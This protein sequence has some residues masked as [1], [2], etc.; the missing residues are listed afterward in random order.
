MS[1]PLSTGNVE[2]SSASSHSEDNDLTDLF[3]F[4]EPE[5]YFQPE[6]PPTFV[7]HTLLSGEQLRLRLVGHNPLWGHLLWNAGQ[8]VSK[9]LQQHGEELIRGKDI[10][11]LGAGAGL[12]GLVSAVLGA[13]KVVITDYPDEDLIQ[14]LK[15]NIE[16]CKLL[17][18]RECEI[19]AEGYLWGAPLSANMSTGFDVLILAD[20]LFNHSEHAKLMSTVQQSMR[21]SATS[22]ALVFFTPYRPWLLEK[23]MAFFDLAREAGFNVRNIL[24]TVIE[25]IMFPK[26]RG[27][28]MLRRTVFGYALSWQ[29]V[30]M[31][32]MGPSNIGSPRLFE[33]LA[34][35]SPRNYTDDD[36][37]RQSQQDWASKINCWLNSQV[38]TSTEANKQIDLRARQLLFFLALCTESRDWQRTVTNIVTRAVWHR[39][40]N[41]VAVRRPGKRLVKLPR[42]EPNRRR[43]TRTS[44]IRAWDWFTFSGSSQSSG[45]GPVQFPED[46]IN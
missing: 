26:D 9:Y 5:G 11:E 36:I 44:P 20:L 16:H 10:L 4:Q 19:S 40:G 24:E 41:N 42:K 8:V 28:E 17:K 2:P 22:K 1:E 32:G 23:D 25:N 6:K 12:P 39:K 46:D 37:G 15:L 34:Y 27:D 45:V 35:C 14:N 30:C 38:Q 31:T 43:R 13:R 21:K 7:E 29:I 3:L 18:N 33:I